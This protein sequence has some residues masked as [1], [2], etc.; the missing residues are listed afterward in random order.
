MVIGQLPAF[1]HESRILDEIF[2]VSERERL[3]GEIVPVGA[4]QSGDAW[5]KHEQHG[6]SNAID[7]DQETNAIPV[8]R[9][10]GGSNPWL[11]VFLN[12]VHCIQQ[13]L[14]YTGRSQGTWTCSGRKCECSEGTYTFCLLYGA[15]VSIATEQAKASSELFRPECINGDIITIDVR[16][17]AWVLPV[18]EIAVI[19]I[20]KGNNM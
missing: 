17:S 3:A 18:H 8:L 20:R 2:V 10:G 5:A 13:V 9:A 12:Q 11:K 14:F 16:S 19:G 4:E 1:D 6:A 15:T 7:L